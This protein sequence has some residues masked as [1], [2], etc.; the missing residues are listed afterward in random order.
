MA[1]RAR[2]FLRVSTMS[3]NEEKQIDDAGE[4]IMKDDDGTPSGVALWT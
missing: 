2:R 4:I 1:D 3:Q